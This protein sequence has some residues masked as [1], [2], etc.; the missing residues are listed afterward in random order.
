MVCV[1]ERACGCVP[2]RT[3]VR[4]C[5]GEPVHACMGGRGL[6]CVEVR[7]W[8][9]ETQR[10]KLELSKQ[11]KKSLGSIGLCGLRGAL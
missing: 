9:R 3:C 4:A 7:A 10:V 8:V 5:V 11:M 2:V 1:R 6:A